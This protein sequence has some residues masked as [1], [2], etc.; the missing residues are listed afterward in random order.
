[1]KSVIRKTQYPTDFT[2]LDHSSLPTNVDGFT[3][4]H[5]RFLFIENKT[6]TESTTGGQ[7]WAMR[8]LAG[9]KQFTML[10]VHSKYHDVSANGTRPFDP[11]SYSLVTET[12]IRTRTETSVE[13]FKKRYSAWFDGDNNAFDYTVE[14]IERQYLNVIPMERK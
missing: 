14:D 5:G 8:S 10:V 3:E 7:A 12:Q 9:C 4:R 2:V 13:D 11:E 6:G 1:M